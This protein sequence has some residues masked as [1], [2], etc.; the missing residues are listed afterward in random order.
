[1]SKM[2]QEILRDP[3]FYKQETFSLSPAEFLAFVWVYRN[4]IQAVFDKQKKV[5]PSSPDNMKNY[6]SEIRY[7]IL[8]G[9]LSKCKLTAEEIKFFERQSENLFAPFK[10]STDKIK[11]PD[12]TLIVYARHTLAALITEREK[13]KLISL[14]SSLVY[15]N[16]TFT[17]GP[18]VETNLKRPY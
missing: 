5:L 18:A 1:M 13:G 4:E 2:D 15:G 8:N 10:N 16:I 6:Y 9:D 3:V 14:E 12:A 11:K 17:I 7:G